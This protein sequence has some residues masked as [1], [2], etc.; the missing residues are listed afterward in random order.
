MTAQGNC[1]DA[2]TL[3]WCADGALMTLA[4]PPGEVC[5][6]HEVFDDG[7]G[8][9]PPENTPCGDIPAEGECTSAGNVVW[10]LESGKLELM[11]CGDDAVCG[12]DSANEWYD[13]LPA[14]SMMAGGAAPESSDEEGGASEDGAETP[15]DGELSPPSDEEEDAGAS[16]ESDSFQDESLQDGGYGPTPGV[17]PGAREET[18]NGT[19]TPTDDAVGCAGGGGDRGASWCF[20]LGALFLFWRRSSLLLS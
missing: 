16:D 4:C 11:Q 15:V 6:A 5:S 3:I 13:C 1:E 18:A 17:T 12:W 7:Y 9:L 8:C 2:E 10:C 20:A 14:A 19:D